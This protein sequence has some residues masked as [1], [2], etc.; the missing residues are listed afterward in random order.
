MTIYD[1][2]C[3]A[4]R[5]VEIEV[6]EGA[7][8]NFLT[9][10]MAA[11]RRLQVR[12][13]EKPFE[14]Q[15]INGDVVCDEYA[16]VTLFGGNG[17]ECQHNV[18]T[19][20]ILRADAPPNDPRIDKPIVGRRLLQEAG[21]LLLTEDPRDPVWSTKMGKESVRL[22]LRMSLAAVVGAYKVLGIHERAEEAASSNC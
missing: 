3:A 7:N 12:S 1:S 21:H 4:R 11:D 8:A 10:G 2:N 15:T 5:F 18:A 9:Q 6:D 14:G 16:E 19:F 13:L 22:S 20:Y 17:D